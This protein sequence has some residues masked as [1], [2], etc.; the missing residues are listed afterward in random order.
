MGGL[1]REGSRQSFAYYGCRNDCRFLVQT[2][3]PARPAPRPQ[4][5]VRDTVAHILADVRARGEAAVLDYT[6]RFDGVTRQT[7]AIRRADADQALASLPGPTREALQW[8]NDRISA[9]ARAQRKTITELSVEVTRGVHVGHRLLPVHA[10]GCYIPGGRHPLPSTALMTILPAKE[11]GVPRVAACAPPGPDGSIHAVTLAAMA[12]AGADEIYCMGGAQAIGALAF[13]TTSVRPVDL[14]VGPGNAYVAE[15]KRQVYG[16]V[17]IDL[18]AGPTELC[19]VAD[20]SADPELAAADLQAQ[21]EHDARARATLV[22]T[23]ARVARATLELV[24][25]ALGHANNP[26]AAR[27]S[28]DENGEVLI[29]SGVDEACA[30]VNALAPEH[31]ELLVAD[32]DTVAS[33]LTAYGALFIGPASSVVFGDYAAGPNHVLPTGGT[34]RFTGGLWVGTFLRVAS[35]TRLSAEGAASLAPFA[36]RLAELEGLPS[37]ASSARRRIKPR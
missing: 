12:L 18:L 19:I 32:P 25:S 35:F 28:W 33:R 26:S 13:G 1:P 34:A 20:G 21:L 22:C 10:A 9:F 5:D 16:Q 15:A 11:A 14:I 3:K 31:V 8:A 29:A 30:K 7:L 2:L 27:T 36:T 23:D 37:H 24:E 4:T 17:G 6:Q